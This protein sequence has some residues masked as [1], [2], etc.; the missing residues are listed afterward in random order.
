MLISSF[1]LCL[2]LQ[3]CIVLLKEKMLEH[4]NMI[5]RLVITDS[6]LLC[7]SVLKKKKSS[8]ITLV[9]TQYKNTQLLNEIVYLLRHKDS[10]LRFEI[11]IALHF[12]KMTYDHTRVSLGHVSTPPPQRYLCVL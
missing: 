3:R 7:F 2:D 9:S 5:F 11:Y 6:V 1:I 12:P 8:V 4:R 10:S